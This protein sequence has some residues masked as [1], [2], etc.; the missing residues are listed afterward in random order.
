MGARVCGE[1]G[2]FS[3]LSL[4]VGLPLPERTLRSPRTV[5]CA[6]ERSERAIADCSTKEPVCFRAPI[7][8]AATP[9]FSWATL[10]SP[11]VGSSH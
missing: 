9:S 3:G 1:S 11:V 8:R 10:E 5:W 7:S 2:E 6:L 4:G